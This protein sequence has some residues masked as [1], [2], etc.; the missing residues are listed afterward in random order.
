[1]RS[2]EGTARDVPATVDAIATP[3]AKVNNG[4]ANLIGAFRTSQ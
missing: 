3:P 1:V 2:E 4:G